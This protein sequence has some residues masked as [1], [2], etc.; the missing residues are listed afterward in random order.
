MFGFFRKD[1]DNSSF[2]DRLH[3]VTQGQ[4]M[5]IYTILA[6]VIKRLPLEERTKINDV[7]KKAAAQGFTGPGAHIKEE[8]R[9]LYKDAMSQL[10][11]S[12]IEEKPDYNVPS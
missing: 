11:Q 6:L 7:L 12:F 9:Q 10:M 4:M 2:N 3:A 1:E 8:Y 5:G